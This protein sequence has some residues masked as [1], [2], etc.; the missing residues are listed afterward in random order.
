MVWLTNHGG[1]G[2]GRLQL[3]LPYV[4]TSSTSRGPP[5]PARG[6]PLDS[7]PAASLASPKGSED[8]SPRG[9][10]GQASG[11]SALGSPV[12]E[13]TEGVIQTG[14][15]GGAGGGLCCEKESCWASEWL[16]W[17]LL[18]LAHAC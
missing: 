10:M 1:G 5:P 17:L 18:P 3:T 9:R 13:S 6:D 12:C 8:F 15:V 4:D 14:W 11:E 7:S 16:E 2:L